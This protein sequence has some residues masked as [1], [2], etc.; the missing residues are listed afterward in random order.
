[1]KARFFGLAHQRLLEIWQYSFESW[2]E[3]QADSYVTGILEFAESLAE[4]PRAG[5]LV[6]GSGFDG[7][8]CARYR[9]HYLFFRRLS[10]GDIGVL[11][12]LH[13]RMDLPARLVEDMEGMR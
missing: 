12:I 4:K 8:Y 6:G 9:H 13:E 11:S 7:I 10:G 1:M 3:N 5:R 2:G